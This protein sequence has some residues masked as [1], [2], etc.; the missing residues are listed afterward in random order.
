MSDEARMRKQLLEAM[1]WC[2]SRVDAKAPKTSL[3]SD[4]LRPQA[5]YDEDD[6]LTI[7]T[8]PAM[9]DQVVGARARLTVGMPQALVGGRILLC[10]HDENNHNWA[11]AEAS[12]WFFDGHDNPPCDTWVGRYEDALVAW[13]PPE[14]VR[15]AQAGIDT[16][17]VGMLDWADNPPRIKGRAT[18]AWLKALA[19]EVRGRTTRCS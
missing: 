18:P 9:I 6:G 15:L 17:C 13:V 8:E 12:Q 10:Y 16:E 1:A 5:E 3:R 2:A 7:W 14:V 11:S 19:A 4:Q